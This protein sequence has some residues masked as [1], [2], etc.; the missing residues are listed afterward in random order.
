M[1]YRKISRCAGLIYK[2]WAGA[3]GNFAPGHWLKVGEEEKKRDEGGNGSGKL[4]RC[5]DF[6]T[7]AV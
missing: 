5:H 4:S 6:L 2:I 7:V 1:S 3:T